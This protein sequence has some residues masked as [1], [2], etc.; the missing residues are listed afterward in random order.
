MLV[1]GQVLTAEALTPRPTRVDTNPLVRTADDFGFLAGGAVVE[2][3]GL[4]KSILALEATDIEVDADRTLAAVRDANGTVLRVDADGADRV[5][6]RPGLLPPPSTPRVRLVGAAVLSRRGD[7]LRPGCRSGRDRLRVAGCVADPR[8]R[9]SRDGTRLA[10]VVRDGDRYAL[11]VAGSFATAH[12][13]RRD[14]VRRR[15]SRSCP[16]RRRPHLDRIER[17]RTHHDRAGRRPPVHAGSRRLLLRV[18]R[19]VANVTTVAGGVQSGGIR[20]RDTA[21][22]LCAARIEL[23]AAGV[24]NPRARGAAGRAALILS[25][26]ARTR[27]HR[28]TP[29]APHVDAAR[30]P[31]CDDLPRLASAPA[32]QT[33]REALSAALSLV[34]PTWCAGCDTPDTP[35]CAACRGALMPPR[36]LAGRAVCGSGPVCIRGRRRPHSAGGEG[37]RPHGAAARARPRPR[38]RRRRRRSP[39]RRPVRSRSSRFRPLRGRCG[40]AGTGSSRRSR[41]ALTSRSGGSSP[42]E[43]SGRS[44]PARSRGARAERRGGDARAAARG[45][46]VIVLDDVVTTGATLGEAERALTAAGAACSA[47]RPWHPPPPQR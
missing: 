14:W 24:R 39:R 30:A 1:D 4:S 18:Q 19:V 7:R 17:P 33:V 28:S 9:V 16:V 41:G 20:V 32:A 25:T 2:I 34:F 22:E 46:R 15:C 47:R 13:R 11:W 42:P 12:R 21:G 8:Q 29:R 26:G 10:A 31:W 35:L 43:R 37:G 27:L 38:R 6:L 3:P 44:A 40:A 45:L 5:D 36:V 23:A